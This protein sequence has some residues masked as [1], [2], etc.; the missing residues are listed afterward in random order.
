MISHLLKAWAR[1]RQK[2]L[3]ACVRYAV[4]Q[5][6]PRIGYLAART[7]YLFRIATG[8]PYFGQ[9]YA[10][11]QGTAAG[12]HN[13]ERGHAR[14][15]RM[16]ALVVEA[17]PRESG[18]ARILEVGAWA[19]W[20]AIIWAKA[21][22]ELGPKDGCVVCVDPWA[23]YL[24][25]KANR[26]PVY[27]AMA[28]ATRRDAIVRLFHHNVRSAGQ[29]DIVHALRGTSDE[30]LPMLRDAWFDL[31][32]IDGDHSYEAV[33]RDLANAS[34]L[35]RQGRILSGDD[36]DLQFDE[37]R[38]SDLRSQL[39][40]DFPLDPSSNS[41]YHPG[42]TLAVWEFFNQRVSSWDGLW[43]MRKTHG[44]WEKVCLAAE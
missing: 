11:A 43:A 33:K 8:K 42:V 38:E 9:L 36:L 4:E 16:R 6:D 30:C 20:S 1:A 28:S 3:R 7:Q 41:R 37:L 29:S 13:I 24:D 23:S 2:G 17:C 10:A 26:D 15:I 40:Y 27:R 31:V 5:V 21:V 32:F 18:E 12:A 22:K 34:R 44:G 35:V 39:T 25:L 14:A 19:G